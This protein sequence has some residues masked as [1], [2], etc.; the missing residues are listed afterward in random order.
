MAVE[1]KTVCFICIVD[2][3]K[4]SPRWHKFYDISARFSVVLITAASATPIFL[5]HITWSKLIVEVVY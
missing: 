1:I 2:K 3:G 5:W 4:T